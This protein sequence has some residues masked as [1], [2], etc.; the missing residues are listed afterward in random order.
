M[1]GDIPNVSVRLASKLPVKEHKRAERI[2][3]YGKVKKPRH[4]GAQHKGKK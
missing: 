3:A 2:T 1:K 4:L